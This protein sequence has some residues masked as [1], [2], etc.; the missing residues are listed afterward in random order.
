MFGS[1]LGAT[2]GLG[3]RNMETPH[4]FMLAVAIV[5]GALIA[6]SQWGSGLMAKFGL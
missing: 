6:R 3:A 1:L 4:Y 5:V 2:L